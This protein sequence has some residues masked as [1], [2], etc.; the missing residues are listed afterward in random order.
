MLNLIKTDIVKK[1][2]Y[3]LAIMVM[4]RTD[5]LSRAVNVFARLVRASFT[6]DRSSISSPLTPREID[7]ARRLLFHLSMGPTQEALD[8]DK[9]SSLRPEVSGGI[10]WTSGRVGQTLERTLGVHQLPILMPGT[11]LARLLMWD[12]H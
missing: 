9:L 12:G 10:I 7:A 1:G 4:K 3:K 2:L 11:E 5:K 8:Q 6:Q